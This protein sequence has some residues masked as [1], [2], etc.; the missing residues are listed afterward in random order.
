[1]NP[2]A[3]LI[4]IGAVGTYVPAGTGYP[5]LAA[6]ATVL[7]GVTVASG[8][9]WVAFGQWLRRMLRTPRRQRI[10]NLTMVV[11]LVASILPSV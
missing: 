6:M 3:W 8:A 5:L 4:C 9:T 1:M 7:A 2:K 11:L 10:F